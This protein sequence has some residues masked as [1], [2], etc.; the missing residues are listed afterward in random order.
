M[1]ACKLTFFLGGLIDWDAKH[2]TQRAIASG[3]LGFT[4]NDAQERNIITPEDWGNDTLER[5]RQGV[6][7]SWDI[8]NS[9]GVTR[10]PTDYGDPALISCWIC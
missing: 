2:T 3:A 1:L 5:T 6:M 8:L 7:G 4:S 10:G 9:L